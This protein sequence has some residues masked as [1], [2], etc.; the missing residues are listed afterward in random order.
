MDQA[1]DVARMM[2]QHGGAGHTT[3]IHTADAEQAVAWG[4]A[5]DYYRVIVNGS[6]VLGSTGG[7]TGLAHTFTIGTGFAGRSSVDGNVGPD[8]LVN[9]K[10]VAFPLRGGWLGTRG[11]AA[12]ATAAGPATATATAATPANTATA[13][14]T[15]E[16]LRVLAEEL[17]RAH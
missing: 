16:L 12:P 13:D 15:C 10:R 9:W 3:G 7:E 6:T 2:L 17:E 8:L 14:I 4:A 5:L 11:A 1:I